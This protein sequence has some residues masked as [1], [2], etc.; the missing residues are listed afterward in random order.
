MKIKVYIRNTLYKEYE[1]T[2]L[3]PLLNKNGKINIGKTIHRL[4]VDIN[5]QDQPRFYKL[6]NIEL[7]IK[8]KQLNQVITTYNYNLNYIAG[9]TNKNIS[10]SREIG[11]LDIYE[12]TTRV[13]KN[14]MYPLNLFSKNKVLNLEFYKNGILE[15]GYT[16][17]T[18]FQINDSNFTFSYANPGDLLEIKLINGAETIIKKFICFPK[19]LQ[20][21]VLG[22]ENDYKMMGI[23]ECTG[24]ISMSSEYKYYTN[25]KYENLVETLDNVSNERQTKLIIHTG[26]LLK[27]EHQVIDAILRSPRCRLFTDD[28]LTSGIDLIPLSKDIDEMSTDQSLYS[29]KLE[30]LINRTHHEKVYSI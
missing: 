14:T 27:E 21:Y 29:Y 2:T 10:A 18:Q 4:M 23:L 25:V 19:P 13:F 9:K 22:Y 6:A 5:F 11:Y 15:F 28:T 16:I 7:I 24:E 26:F 8:E 1:L 20:K 12:G 17:S 30:F 3:I